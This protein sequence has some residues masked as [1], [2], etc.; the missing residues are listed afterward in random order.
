MVKEKKCAVCKETKL[1]SEFNLNRSMRDGIDTRCKPCNTERN[2]RIYKIRSS[3]ENSKYGMPSSNCVYGIKKDGVFVYIGSS[4]NAPW[5]V[6]LH[7]TRKKG[8][9][10]TCLRDFT[11]LERQL[12]FKWHVLWYGDIGMNDERV[13]QE[14]N[15]IQIHQPKFNKI[16]YKTYEG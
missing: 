8:D 7:M 13:H 1:T 4:V 6:H 12:N 16:K 3:M 9:S 5:R 10:R 2:K 14:K 15:L 11:P